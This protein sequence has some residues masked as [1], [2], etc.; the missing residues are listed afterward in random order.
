MCADVTR[1]PG[2]LEVESARYCVYVKD[3]SG[4]KETGV[5]LT[6]KG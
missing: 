5:F 2:G 3:L 6:L 1:A 4:K